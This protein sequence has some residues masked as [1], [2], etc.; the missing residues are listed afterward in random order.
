MVCA[1]TV[2]AL[3]NDKVHPCSVKNRLLRGKKS[4][5]LLLNSKKLTIFVNQSNDFLKTSKR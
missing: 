5:Y 4:S 1:K 3:R 2:A